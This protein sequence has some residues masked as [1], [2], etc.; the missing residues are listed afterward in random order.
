MASG[1]ATGTATATGTGSASGTFVYNSA[2][3]EARATPYDIALSVKD[4][5]CAGKT[6]VDVIRITVTRPSGPTSISGD[7]LVC[8]LNTVSTYTAT[9]GTAP[10]VRW[11]ALGGTIVGNNTGRTVQVK[12]TTVGSGTVVAK[13]ISSY[14]CP[15]DSLSQTVAVA[16]AGTLSVGG[17][18]SICQ[19][20]S[21]TLTITG[22]TAPYTLSGGGITQSGSGPFTVTPSQTTTYTIT[23]TATTNGCAGTAQVTVAVVP[24]PAANVGAAARSTCS[25]SAIALGSTPVAGNTYSWSPATGLSSSTVANPTLTLTNTTGSPIVATYSLTETSATGG[26][27]ATNTVTITVNPAVVAVPGAGVTFCSGSSAQL[28]APAVAGFTYSWSPTTGLSSPTAANPTVTL[29]NTT[30]APIVTTYTLTVTNTA[31]GCVGSAT[32][33]VTVNPLPIVAAGAAATICSGS[34]AQLGAPA[35]AGF[36]YSW[37]PTT[38]LSSPTAAN[39]TVTLTNTTGAPIVTT[40]TL[41]VTNTATGCVGSATVAVTVNPLP[42]AVPGASVITCSGV[43]VTIGG[44][45]VAGLTYTWSPAIGLSSPT[46]ANPTVTLTNTTG[47]PVTQTYTLTVTNAATSCVSVA[48]VVV[49]VN[50]AVVAVPGAGVTFC[51]GSSAQLGTPAVAG[52]T[53]SWSPTTGLS[54]PTAANPTVTLTN[55]TG[56]PIVTTYTLTVTNTATGCV[57]S[58]TVAVTVNPLPIVA[59]G[60]AATICSGNSAQLGASAVTGFTYNWSPATGLS[61]PTAANPTVTLTNTTGAPVTQ[62]YTLTVTNTATGCVNTG[63]VAVTVNPAATAA[64]GPAQAVCDKSTITLGTAALP[65]YTYRWTPAA[66]LSSASVA[67]PVLTGVNT[68]NAPLVQK[69]VVLA[70]TALGCSSKDS[71]LITINPRPV[72]DTIVGPKSVCPTITGITYAIANPH[73]TTYQWVVTGV[74]SP[75]PT[76][77]LPLR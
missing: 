55:T 22:G 25:G 9:G 30:S 48:S 47:A 17:G 74:E 26:C 45:P 56:A 21:T 64:A 54:S 1:A 5:G 23:G 7:A 76:A 38:G 3:G 2:C 77:A 24:L 14:G 59:A 71:V 70:T 65:G 73:S 19:G 40:Y 49:T 57:G 44:A 31:T 11:R 51:S 36:T 32:V 34:S 63:T 29:T 46:A 67:Q 12:W 15:T 75:A 28:G 53:Y 58:A 8:S 41:T 37:S 61:N 10:S 35:V 50:P 27:T 66:N 20:T 68:T 6:A 60:A 39:P 42:T 52:F 16:P 62:T 13:G 72:A 43:P 33:A 69:Y 18:L 4:I